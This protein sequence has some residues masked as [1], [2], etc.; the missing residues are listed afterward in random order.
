[1]IS[2]L[3]I[4]KTSLTI[5]TKHLVK[6]LLPTGYFIN[7]DVSTLSY[8]IYLT[9]EAEAVAIRFKIVLAPLIT[10]KY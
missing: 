6:I 7:R 8:G 3:T 1:M 10:M 2:K 5:D 4:I 9:S